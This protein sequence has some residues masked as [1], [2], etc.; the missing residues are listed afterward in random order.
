MLVTALA[1]ENVIFAD[2]S[3]EGRIDPPVS[4]VQESVFDGS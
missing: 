4:E 2:V 1:H 3:A